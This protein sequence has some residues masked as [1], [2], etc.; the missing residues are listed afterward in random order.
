MDEKNKKYKRVL[1]ID[2]DPI[3]NHINKRLM[4]IHNVAQN[5]E[6]CLSAEEALTYLKNQADF[7]EIIF[8]DIQMPAMDGF[9]FL[10]SYATLP[11]SS[12]KNTRL[13]VLSS[14]DNHNELEKIHDNKA[15][16]GF[17]SKPLA[18]AQIKSL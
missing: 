18:Q 6:C 15:V 10:E 14:T 16:Y 7:P 5:I 3:I 1:L 13:I 2:D 9:E 4:E 17:F 11:E 8:L 12:K